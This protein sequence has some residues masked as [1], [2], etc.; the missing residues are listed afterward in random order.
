MALK[1]GPFYE[2]L[3]RTGECACPTVIAA[4][5]AA[6]GLSPDLIESSVI[7]G[8]ID[9]QAK[10]IAGKIFI[11]AGI[12][13][14]DVTEEDEAMAVL[15][16]KE[17]LNSEIITPE[18]FEAE[19]SDVA[20]WLS[21]LANQLAMDEADAFKIKEAVKKVGYLVSVK[22]VDLNTALYCVYQEG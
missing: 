13:E 14:T 22:G 7:P 19:K 2:E 8:A 18:M 10:V 6:D 9:L 20:Y 11:V 17:M 5:A 16:T 21:F 3:R 12:D 4:Q 1:E 15:L